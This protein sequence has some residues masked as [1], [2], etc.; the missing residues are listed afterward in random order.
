MFLCQEIDINLCHCN[1][2]VYP[3]L[4]P[5]VKNRFI[6][7]KLFNNNRR[8]RNNR[9]D[10]DEKM[11]KMWLGLESVVAGLPPLSASFQFTKNEEKSSS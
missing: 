1:T 6:F 4:C 11:R 2:L 10:S 9:G 5:N 7:K 8:T 3:Y